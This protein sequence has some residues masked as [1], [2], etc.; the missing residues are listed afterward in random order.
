MNS[1]CSILTLAAFLFSPTRIF[2]TALL[3][4]PTFSSRSDDELSTRYI[5]KYKDESLEYKI[6]LQNAKEGVNE[7]ALDLFSSPQGIQLLDHGKFLP[8][9][10]AEIMYFKSEEEINAY[11]E[12]EDVEYVEL[13]HKVY[14][15]SEQVPYGIKNVK[16]LL[17]SDADV[18]NRKVCIIDT[19]YDITHP[20][21]TS[22]L[23]IVTGY[24]GGYSAGPT[25]WS[26]D[27]NGHGTH[28]AGTIAAIGGNGK[29]VVG[30]N[31]NG[32]LKLHIVKVF[33]DNGKWAWGSNLLAAVEICVDVGANIINMS[34][35]GGGFSQTECNTYERI[36]KENDVLTI[37]AAGNLGN[38]AY[39][40]P[41]SYEYV[42]SVAATDVNNQIASFSQHN[43]QVDI[44]A[45]GKYILS[46][47][48]SNVSS[49][50]YREL[51]GTSMATPHVSGVAALVWS[52]DTTKSAAEIR[53]A[54][55]ESA[56]DLGDPGRDNYYGNGLVR[57]DRANAL[58]DSGFTLHPTSAPTLD[59][60]TDDPIG[61]YDIDGEDYNCEWYATGTAC[62]QY[63]NGFENFGTIANEACCAC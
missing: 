37:A 48:P 17:V 29:G 55:E 38:T 34:L 61:W 46:T 30:V 19:G 49:T 9:A 53:R 45:P 62:E 54:L 41:A 6:R 21:L 22:D 24:G 5:V 4:E 35:G 59:S 39:S 57:A 12:K 16:A 43:N 50:M 7:E 44:A 8:K 18:S 40:Y 28:V 27:G 33:G 15:L 20:D 42:M 63:G 31:R 47:S 56:E 58:L 13:D 3:A 36:F 10:N 2:A 14:L 52:R 51:S 1:C 23:T 11:E 26:Y 32:E 25:P 60:C